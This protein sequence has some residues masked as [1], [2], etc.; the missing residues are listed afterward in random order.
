[1]IVGKGVICIKVGTKLAEVER[2]R[3]PRNPLRM[4]CS[5]SEASLG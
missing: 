5:R 1:M 4:S 3:R 2:V